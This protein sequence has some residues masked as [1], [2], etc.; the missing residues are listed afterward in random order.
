MANTRE[1]VAMFGNGATYGNASANRLR[2]EGDKLVNYN[3]IIA[4]RFRGK[5][6][7]NSDSYSQT[8]TKHQ[9]RIREYADYETNEETINNLANV[10]SKEEEDKLLKQIQENKEQ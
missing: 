3:T 4:L 2:I 9:N 10:R 1:L 8:T 6:I 7:L 5:Y